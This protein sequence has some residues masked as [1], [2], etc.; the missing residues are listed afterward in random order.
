[1]ILQ[2]IVVNFLFISF[3]IIRYIISLRL[4]APALLMLESSS[5]DTIT[6]ARIIISLQVQRNQVIDQQS[7]N[8]L[9][10]KILALYKVKKSYTCVACVG[11]L[12]KV[13][14]SRPG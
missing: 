12:G 11:I 5:V 10:M 9:G 8:F 7:H 2:K 3:I 4:R 1:M 6:S 13:L 14:G